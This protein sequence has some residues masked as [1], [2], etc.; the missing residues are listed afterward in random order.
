MLSAVV[1]K[2]IAIESQ[3]ASNY[4]PNI[5][6]PTCFIE[7]CQ[8]IFVVIIQD[9]NYCKVGSDV[10]D[11]ITFSNGYVHIS[12]ELLELL[13]GGI[14]TCHFSNVRFPRVEVPAK[15]LGFH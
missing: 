15:I 5:L 9:D 11:S 3:V 13:K 8:V 4:E 1:N 7:V 14:G 6:V 10:I 2:S 12:V